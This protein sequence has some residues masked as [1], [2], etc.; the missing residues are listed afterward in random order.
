[1]AY[2][3]ALLA[4]ITGAIAGVVAAAMIGIGIAS[5]IGLADRDGVALTFALL[6]VG[7]LG[8]ALGLLLGIFLAFRYRGY[9]KLRSIAWR[10][11][12]VAL[13]IG[14]L[15]IGGIGLARRFDD[16][17]GHGGA[18]RIMEFEIRAPQGF[19]I[20][21]RGIEV[22]LRSD[23][24]RASADLRDGAR[25]VAD[26][27]PVIAG[28][29]ELRTR[30]VRRVLA[31]SL[32]E[33][34]RRLFHLDLPA[35]PDPSPAFGPWRRVDVLDDMKTDRPPRPA[36]ASDDFEVRVRVGLD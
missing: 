33:Q 4:G 10:G 15:G 24:Q 30:A 25:A 14:G 28:R 21:S 32:P 13:V 3:T 19:A 18:A 34:P 1:M 6:G 17:L 26:G 22:E 23:R 16:A 29:V 8:G 11:L 2:V 9:K 35:D 5:A 27:R 7:P 20:A 12:I 31:L 36:P